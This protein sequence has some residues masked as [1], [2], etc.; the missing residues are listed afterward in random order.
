MLKGVQKVIYYT[1]Y[2]LN[3]FV[4][5]GRQEQQNGK[6]GLFFFNMY[7]DIAGCNALV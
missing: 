7:S 6:A 2:V 1:H 3:T 5:T 4:V